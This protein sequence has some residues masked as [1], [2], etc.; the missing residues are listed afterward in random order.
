MWGQWVDRNSVPFARFCCEPEA[1]LKDKVYYFFKK[2]MWISLTTCSSAEVRAK[3]GVLGGS[4]GSIDEA[5]SPPSTGQGNSTPGSSPRSSASHAYSKL[6]L[7][8]NIRR[9]PCKPYLHEGL[10]HFIKGFPVFAIVKRG[11]PDNFFL[12]V[13]N[14]HRKDIF[15][16]PSRFVQ[17]LFLQEKNQRGFP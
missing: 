12:L 6:T 1:A 11:H 8:L 13:H 9:P 7:N 14:G 2:G 17:R 10:I 5:S 4:Q 15:N 3:K 16:H